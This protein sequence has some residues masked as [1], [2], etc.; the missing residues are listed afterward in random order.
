MRTV[1][2]VVRVEATGFAA[3]ADMGFRMQFPD[4][5]S[6]RSFGRAGE[7]GGQKQES[8]EVELNGKT[9]DLVSRFSM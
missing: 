5:R 9:H 4:S 8:R 7:N 6:Q 1:G 3:V 2:H